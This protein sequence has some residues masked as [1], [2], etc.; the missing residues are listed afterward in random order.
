MVFS[1]SLNAIFPIKLINPK[2]QKIYLLLNIPLLKYFFGIHFKS[3]FDFVYG[4]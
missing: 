3:P 2:E 1:L 4:I